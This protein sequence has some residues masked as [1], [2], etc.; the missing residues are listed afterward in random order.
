MYN[1]DGKYYLKK[2]DDDSEYT[3]LKKQAEPLAIER[4]EKY[5]AQEKELNTSPFE[6]YGKTKW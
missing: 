6:R 1:G 2:D 4:F 3:N 5:K